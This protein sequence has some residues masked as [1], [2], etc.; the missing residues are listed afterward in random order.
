MSSSA[1]LRLSSGEEKGAQIEPREGGT[2][3]G[4][5]MDS[6]YLKR[7][8]VGGE[9]CTLLLPAGEKNLWPVQKAQ[10]QDSKDTSLRPDAPVVLLTRP[11][12]HLDAPRITPKEM[13]A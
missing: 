4:E 3:S 11:R 6:V 2:G 7:H 12:G 9:G 10:C 1:P 5:M 8:S 13:G